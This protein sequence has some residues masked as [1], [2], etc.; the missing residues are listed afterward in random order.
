V[1]AHGTPRSQL[2]RLV[3]SGA[4]ADLVLSK[5]REVRNLDLEEAFGILTCL[6]GDRRYPAAARRLAARFVTERP[7]FTLEDEATLLEALGRFEHDAQAA[8]PALRA[9]L[10]HYALP[11]A[12]SLLD[13]LCERD[14]RPDRRPPS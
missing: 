7:A 1:T 13:A 2:G 5:A 9:V 8:R 11:R 4:N 3:R 10:D 14:P 6:R 12:V